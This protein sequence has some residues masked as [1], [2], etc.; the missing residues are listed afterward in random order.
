VLQVVVPLRQGA[1]SNRVVADLLAAFQPVPAA[2]G[3]SGVSST[4]Q[5]RSALTLSWY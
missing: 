1:D 3:G 2:G 4:V 5:A